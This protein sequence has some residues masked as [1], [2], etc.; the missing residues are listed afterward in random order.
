MYKIII[1]FLLN[2][3]LISTPYVVAKNNQINKYMGCSCDS[4]LI[5]D[6]K[7][8]SVILGYPQPITMSAQIK[9]E[10]IS[11][12]SDAMLTKNTIMVSSLTG[13]SNQM[14][15]QL[16]SQL[17][18]SMYI[19]YDNQGYIEKLYG[20]KNTPVYDYNAIK[21]LLLSLQFCL[22]EK[23]NGIVKEKDDKGIALV[24]YNI[25]DSQNIIKKQRKHYEKLWSANILMNIDFSD[26][27]I[28]LK[29]T[30]VIEK[31]KLRE[32]ITIGA[33]ENSILTARYLQEFQ[34][35]EINKNKCN[36][37]FSLK[38]FIQ[39]EKL[40]EL[41]FEF[42]PDKENKRL[43]KR[44]QLKSI[45]LHELV[46]NLKSDELKVWSNAFVLL[47]DLLTYYPENLTQILTLIESNL[48]NK[49]LIKSLISATAYAESLNAQ[50]TLLE[51]IKQFY[52]NKFI[53]KNAII[54]HHFS[55]L[56]SQDNVDYLI[57]VYRNHTDREIRKLT[58]LAIGSLAK[59]IDAIKSKEQKHPITEFIL[60]ELSL[61]E[62]N[63]EKYIIF[64]ALG[65]T[66][67][68]VAYKALEKIAND[69]DKNISSWAN[70]AMQ[71][72]SVE[73]IDK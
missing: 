69:S 61:A 50:A 21:T 60:K 65:N 67:D 20:K 52:K 26:I 36:H 42:V 47:V 7:S 4:T 66:G 13:M 6:L 28:H 29:Q 10:P 57:S 12:T 38:K 48:E 68:I 55:P 70:E 24:E 59:K 62:S 22:P 40:I 17:N 45:N 53:L 54:G 9:I 25:T 58:I 34:L 41:P 32:N 64:N 18:L 8:K 5:Y 11:I 27:T 14:T 63:G 39:T 31:I 3:F 73:L 43:A 23:R 19:Y 37:Y 1:V 15:S 72:I 51:I 49:K 44:E 30:G 16:L 35:K 46:S 2:A 71:Q 33:D 56:P